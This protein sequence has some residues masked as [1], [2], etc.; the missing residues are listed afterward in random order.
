[1]RPYSFNISLPNGPVPEKDIFLNVFILIQSTSSCVAVSIFQFLRL[2]TTVSVK[3]S[4]Y[5]SSCSLLTKPYK[6]VTLAII[7]ILRIGG[8]HQKS[9]N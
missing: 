9:I 6:N 8:S 5:L 2:L 1:M 3:L 4:L 7:N